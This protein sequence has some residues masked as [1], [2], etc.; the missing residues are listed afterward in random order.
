MTVSSI[1]TD[2]SVTLAQV[3][4]AQ[5]PASTP[6]VP[7]TPK[8]CGSA[9]QIVLGPVVTSKS[10]TTPAPVALA[11]PKAAAVTKPQVAAVEAKNSEAPV[12]PAKTFKGALLG[13][14]KLVGKGVGCVAIAP[15]VG[16]LAAVSL[17][18]AVVA[19]VVGAVVGALL[20]IKEGPSSS[21]LY[22]CLGFQAGLEFV[23]TKF[24]QALRSLTNLVGLNG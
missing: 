24:T 11:A 4:A 14:L 5:T 15:L 22:G 1:K 3:S 19:P 9:D 7:S 20:A 10:A 21:A 8:S 16:A 13:A 18:A 6:S 23:G 17:A 12:A 2:S